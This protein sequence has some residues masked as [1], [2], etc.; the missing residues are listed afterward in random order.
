MP[1]PKCAKVDVN[2]AVSR[3][4]LVAEGWRCV[5]ILETY[6][7]EM[8]RFFDSRIEYSSA[9]P[10]V[11]AGQ[12][13]WSGR[14]WRDDQVSRDDAWAETEKVLTNEKYY[15]YIL[16][17]LPAAFVVCSVGTVHL[18]GTHPFAR[19][20]GL[21]KMLVQYAA[22]GGKITA[23]TYA[24]NEAAKRLYQS[25]GMSVIKSQAVFHK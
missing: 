5:G 25:L 8:D 2:D 17:S 9:P 10:L 19:G 1:L 24:D 18:I 23:G 14:L 21:A 12:I 20:L 11:T 4:S 13:S 22:H 16:G 7:G 3:E 15:T 6:S